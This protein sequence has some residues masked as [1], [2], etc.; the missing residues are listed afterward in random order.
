MTTNYEHVKKRLGVVFHSWQKTK[1]ANQTSQHAGQ[2]S[3]E[4]EFPSHLRLCVQISII[5]WEQAVYVWGSLGVKVN[6]TCRLH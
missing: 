5:H 4:Q 2:D 1:G 3:L 6:V